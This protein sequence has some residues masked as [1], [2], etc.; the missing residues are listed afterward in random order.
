M[1]LE[2]SIDI[3][4]PIARVWD[5]TVDIE[6]WPTLTPTILSVER[7]DGGP[8]RV[9]SRARV[10]QPRLPVAVWTVT[11]LEPR[12]LFV[13]ETRMRG[14]RFV[15]SH[16]LSRTADG[17]RNTLTLDVDGWSAGLLSALAGSAMQQAIATEN[18]G[19]LRVAQSTQQ[20]G[21]EHTR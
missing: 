1:H 6:Q 19:F 13:W 4:A 17:T 3:P 5:L 7:L 11:E 14:A 15:G 21:S 10:A 20:P 2:N 18:A 12:T 16:L 9:G 8:L